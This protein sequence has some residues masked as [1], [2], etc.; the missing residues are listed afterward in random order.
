MGSSGSNCNG[1]V[2]N[3]GNGHGTHVT[4]TVISV[5]YGLAR[6]A[7]AISVRVLNSGGSGS[8]E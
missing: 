4:G 6:G 5:V 3:D 8:Y 1:N 2:D 7:T